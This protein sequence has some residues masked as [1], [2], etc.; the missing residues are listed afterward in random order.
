MKNPFTII[1]RR[2]ILLISSVI[3]ERKI[4]LLKVPA[5]RRFSA[6]VPFIISL[7]LSPS[8]LHPF[9]LSPLWGNTIEGLQL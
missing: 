4:T 3:T 8:P 5:S 7:P 9:S 2:K 1:D 6:S